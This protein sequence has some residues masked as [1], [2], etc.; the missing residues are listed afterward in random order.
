MLWFCIDAAWK[1]LFY[2]AALRV[3]FL[4]L[5]GFSL[6]IE[7]GE[8]EWGWLAGCCRRHRRAKKHTCLGPVRG[9]RDEFIILYRRALSLSLHWRRFLCF[10]IYDAK[11]EFPIC[12]LIGSCLMGFMI[13]WFS[14][15]QDGA[16]KIVDNF[17]R[18]WNN[19]GA[20]KWSD[21]FLSLGS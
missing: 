6:P 12:S 19:F 21:F 9:A 13:S 20:S 1:S 5:G 17:S 3:L 4:Y 10:V 11:P 15:D 7:P 16:V 2:E 18:G 14:F 8:Y